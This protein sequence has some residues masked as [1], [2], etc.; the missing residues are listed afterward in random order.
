MSESIRIYNPATSGAKII[1]TA[2]RVPDITEQL[3]GIIVVKTNKLA[4]YLTDTEIKQ[5]GLS[6]NKH[7]DSHYTQLLYA[8]RYDGS[9][10]Y[11]IEG[12]EPRECLLKSLEDILD[13]SYSAT[14]LIKNVSESTTV[15]EYEAGHLNEPMPAN[16]LGDEDQIILHRAKLAFENAL[17]LTTKLI[18]DTKLS[19]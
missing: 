8:G 17:T 2:I 4:E 18:N 19:D 6:E 10:L 11:K 13:E 1:C 14:K 9:A 5:L 3:N 12:S 15:I 7:I 16:I